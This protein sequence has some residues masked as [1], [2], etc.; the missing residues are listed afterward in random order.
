MKNEKNEKIKNKKKG[1]LLTIVQE[2][3]SFSSSKTK[4]ALKRKETFKQESD[5]V[6]DADPS[7]PFNK[8]LLQNRWPNS[9]SN[10]LRK[11][12]LSL[13]FSKKKALN[14]KRHEVLLHTFPLSRSNSP[15]LLLAP[16]SN[17]G[18]LNILISL[19]HPVCTNC[20]HCLL[21]GLTNIGYI[22]VWLFHF[23]V[24]VACAITCCA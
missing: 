3:C 12:R 6:E 18:S 2:T 22:S 17:P 21:Y 10:R 8:E 13:R 24:V 16:V 9:C 5:Q 15:S 23:I 4:N 11:L 7:T 1:D 19:F 14:A 20:L